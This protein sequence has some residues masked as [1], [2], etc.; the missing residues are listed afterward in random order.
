[1]S[2]PNMKVL[3]TGATGFIG[4]HLAE[5]LIKRGHKV[6]CFVRSSSSLLWLA[7]LELEYSYGSLFDKRTIA[8][9]LR[10]IDYVYHLAGV[11]KA[12]DEN[13]FYRGNVEATKNLIETILEQK[14]NLKRFL[15]VSSQAAYGPSTGIEP[16]TE[17]STA[18]P[19]T[20]YGRSKLHSQHYVENHF[21]DI[22]ATIVMP[23][24]VYGPRDKDTLS[25]FKTVKNGVVPLLQGKDRFASMVFVTDLVQ[26]MIQAA[27]SKKSVGQKYFLCDQYPYSWS[28]V[29]RITLNILGKRA[30]HISIPLAL[31]KL[32]ASSTEQINKFRNKPGILSRQKVIEMQ[33]DS[34]VCSSKKAREELDFNP[35][36]P[37]SENIKETLSWY[38]AHGWL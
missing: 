15:F 28:E 9:A 3:I 10:D 16:I 26:G 11:T 33:Q 21:S 31:M 25:F 22:P 35:K 1:M 5:S 6:R 2:M 36:Q 37:V 8:P 19:L 34:W 23:S 20:Y 7:D 24:T 18:Q 29:A 32:V 12:F 13:G 4:S 38:L 17:Q 27:E 30:I 14:L